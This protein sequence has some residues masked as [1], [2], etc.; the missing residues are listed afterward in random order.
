MEGGNNLVLGYSV[1]LGHLRVDIRVGGIV[2]V[3]IRIGWIDF[4]L[5]GSLNTFC[6][7]DRR[8]SVVISLPLAHTNGALT[9]H[10]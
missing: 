5:R 4:R 3:E 1:Q 2:I 7:I 9:N 8:V 6:C 10:M